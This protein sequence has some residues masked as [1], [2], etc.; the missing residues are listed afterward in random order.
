MEQE[1]I[2]HL[3]TRKLAGEASSDELAELRVLLEQYPESEQYLNYMDQV[4]Q[5]NTSDANIPD[6]DKSFEQ[7]LQRHFN[8]TE[9]TTESHPG[10]FSI[11]RYITPVLIAASMLLCL[12]IGLLYLYQTNTSTTIF[13]NKGERKRIILPDNTL[14]WLNS[15]SEISYENNWSGEEYNRTV[16]LIGEAFFDVSHDKKHPFIIKTDKYDVKVLGTS[17]NIRAYPKENVSETSLLRGKIELSFHKD[18]AKKIQLRPNEKLALNINDK[19]REEQKLEERFVIEN[20][21][22]VALQ[23]RKIIAETSW[24]N[25]RVVLN[26]DDFETCAEKL[27]R[28]F[29]VKIIIKDPKIRT[30]RY[31][32]I[33]KDESLS[34]ALKA[35]NQINPFKYTINKDEVIIE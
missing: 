15:N 35:M 17:F 12:S 7:H 28:K 25:N 33:F 27:E 8:K 16:K 4:W 29:N 11:K 5:L 21:K 23:K 30:Q 3:H 24:I 6:V 14:V 9:V 19:V 32:G 34:D 31:T 2:I 20:I 22:P 18:P 26:N 1:R 10:V 13:S